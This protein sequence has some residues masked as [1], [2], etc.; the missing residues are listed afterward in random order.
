MTLMK[1]T[2]RYSICNSL[3]E[4]SLLF[5]TVID[6]NPMSLSTVEI[7]IPPIRNKFHL[8]LA[9][10]QTEQLETTEIPVEYT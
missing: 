2:L 7:S 8:V 10:P 6:R 5:Q 1:R 9:W 4:A 3:H